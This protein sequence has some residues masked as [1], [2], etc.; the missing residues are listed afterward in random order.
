MACALAKCIHPGYQAVPIIGREA[1][2]VMA[3]T[4]Q[5]RHWI[6]ARL[7]GPR[8]GTLLFVPGDDGVRQAGGAIMRERVI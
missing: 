4:E 3:L 6:N 2:L 5:A 7:A 8:Q 1:D